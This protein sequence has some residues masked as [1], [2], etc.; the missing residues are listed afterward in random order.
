[1]IPDI[2]NVLA[3]ISAPIIERPM[4][5]SKLT[6]WAE[7][8]SAPSNEYFEFEDQPASTSPNTPTDET[9]RMNSNPMFTLATVGQAAPHGITD[10]T[11]KAATTEMIGAIKKIARSALSGT[12]SSLTSSLIPS[13]SG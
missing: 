13:A 8:L 6:I 3:N 5:I 2:D 4:P 11:T 9:A 1:M 7:D 12:M 10:N